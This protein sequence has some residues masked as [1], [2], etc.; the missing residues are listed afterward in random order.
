MSI[1]DPDKQRAAA[2][3]SALFSSGWLGEMTARAEAHA[4]HVAACS[5]T[6]CVQCGR[7]L[8]PDCGAPSSMTTDGGA[9]RCADCCVRGQR[10][11]RVDAARE[12]VPQRFRWAKLDDPRLAKIVGPRSL[13]AAHAAMSSERVALFGAPGSGKT[14]LACAM[15]RALHDGATAEGAPEPLIRRA[16][17][18]LFVSAYDLSKARAR[19]PLGQGEAPLIEAALTASVLVIDDLGSERDG[20]QSAVTEVLYERHAE[21]R[22]TWVTTWLDVAQATA[23]YGGGIARR[24]FEGSR[25]INLDRGPTQ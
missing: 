6:P 4:A 8:C 18:S 25:R 16:S 10:A 20:F 11:S 5:E 1:D 12:S 2:E 17:R 3:L 9:L 23:R 21:C 13:A 19:H 7:A 14:S 15:L 24:L 22:T